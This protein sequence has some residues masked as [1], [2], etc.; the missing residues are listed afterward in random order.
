MTKDD[1]L[2]DNNTHTN[3]VG[4]YTWT[5]DVS[6]IEG[7]ENNYNITINP[8]KSTVDKGHLTITVDDSNTTVGDNPNYGGTVD[9][10]ANGDN[11]N[12]FDIN[13]GL[14]DDS[15]IGQPGKHDGVIGVII[16]GTFYPSGTEDDIFN[17]YDVTINAG[18]L[19]VLKPFDINNNKNWSHLYKDAPWDRNRDFKERKAEFNFVDGAIPLDEAVEEV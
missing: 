15:I 14:D 12:D 8:G 9:G 17:N 3:D 7:L 13:F 5:G 19:T 10:W 16:D 1:A 4:D 6:G 18:D 2:K 11:P